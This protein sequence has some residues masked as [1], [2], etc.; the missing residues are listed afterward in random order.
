VIF[1]LYTFST[2]DDH[3]LTDTLLVNF[4]GDS[5]FANVH[6]PIVDDQILEHPELFSLQISIPKES[7]DIGIILG[8]LV[9]ANVTIIDNDG[10]SY[11]VIP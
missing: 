8:D 9:T 11:F 1:T 3:L 10:K 6:V 5:L 4:N 2:E 7:A